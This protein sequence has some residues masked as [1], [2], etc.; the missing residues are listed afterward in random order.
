MNVNKNN[1]TEVKVNNKARGTE[2]TLK[3]QRFKLHTLVVRLHI[4][5]KLLQ[6]YSQTN[7]TGDYLK[8]KELVV[9]YGRW[10]LIRVELQVFFKEN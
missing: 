4:F 5:E 9:A 6:T 7:P 2:E 3:I 8:Y 1:L 10:S